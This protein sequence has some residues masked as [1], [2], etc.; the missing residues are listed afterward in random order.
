MEKLKAFLSEYVP[1]II[2]SLIVFGIPYAYLRYT[3]KTVWDLV[4]SPK[5][6]ISDGNV[7]KKY[8]ENR[9]TILVNKEDFTDDGIR[10]FTSVSVSPDGEKICF[11][12]HTLAP[13]WVYWSAIDGSDP[14]KVGLAEN[15]VWSNASDKIAYTNHTT[16]VSPH[17]VFVYDLDLDETENMTES[18]NSLED[19]RIYQAP[20]WSDD[21]S[22]ILGDYIEYDMNDDM[23]EIEGTTKITV[24]TGELEEFEE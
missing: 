1:W 22:Y 10:K 7:V 21:D 15:C 9:E 24:Y 2:G 17:N 3:D 8:S 11:T 4:Y 12:G 5:I 23:E 6:T 14:I 20:R 19:M 13:I 16:D 18:V